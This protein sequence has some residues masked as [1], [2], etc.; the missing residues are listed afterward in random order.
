ML[1]LL[2][3]VEL[4]LIFPVVAEVPCNT[5]PPGSPNLTVPPEFTVKSAFVDP[6][7]SSIFVPISKVVPFETIKA[8]R[9]LLLEAAVIVPPDF[10]NV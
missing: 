10:V 9:L 5:I 3:E 4:V 2:I 6:A 1:K 7:Q 8:I